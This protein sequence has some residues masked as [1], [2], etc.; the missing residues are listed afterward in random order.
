[1]SVLGSSFTLASPLQNYLEVDFSEA[2]VN[3]FVSLQYQYLYA[4]PYGRGY[5][6][7]SGCRLEDGCSLFYTGGDS[8]D[9]PGGTGL[10]SGGSSGSLATGGDSCPVVGT[11]NLPNEDDLAL[12]LVEGDT[13]I[14]ACQ[15]GV[16]IGR[17]VFRSGPRPPPPAGVSSFGGR[18]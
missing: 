9:G 13:V 4:F 11:R 17:C 6:G 5:S 16:V 15:N 2:G 12:F 18:K 10:G 8:L 3:N 14:Y 1:V 7:I